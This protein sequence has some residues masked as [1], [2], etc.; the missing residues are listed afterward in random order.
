MPRPPPDSGEKVVIEVDV[1]PIRKKKR[2][3]MNLATKTLQYQPG[4]KEDMFRPGTDIVDLQNKCTNL[5]VVNVTQLMNKIRRV[6]FGPGMNHYA[7]AAHG[8]WLK[9]VIN[10]ETPPGLRWEGSADVE[11]SCGEDKTTTRQDVE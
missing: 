10:T 8:D 5:N 6:I 9:L 2:Y 4:S 3:Y 1:F 11:F 7:K